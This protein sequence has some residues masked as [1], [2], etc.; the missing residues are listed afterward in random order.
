DLNLQTS[1]RVSVMAI[2]SLLFCLAASLIVN[3][4]IL[5]TLILIPLLLLLNWDVYQFFAQK[6]GFWFAVKVIPLHWLY[7][8]YAGLS[9]VLGTLSYWQAALFGNEKTVNRSPASF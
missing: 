5:P 9:F 4:A 7:Y 3:S 1:D 2:Y 6:R 8:F